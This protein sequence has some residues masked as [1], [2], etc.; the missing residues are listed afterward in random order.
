MCMNGAARP[1]CHHE[2]LLSTVLGLSP[3]RGAGEAEACRLPITAARPV[4][5]DYA[6]VAL[7]TVIDGDEHGADVR[8]DHGL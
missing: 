2:T 3:R 1:G 6:A 8:F 4:R 7:A 5:A